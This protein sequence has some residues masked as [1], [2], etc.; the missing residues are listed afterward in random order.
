LARIALVCEPPDG[1]VAEHVMHLAR[2]LEAH[3]HT[4]LLFVAPEFKYRDV[5]ETH[6]LP[7]RRDY[8]HPREDLRALT[9]LVRGVRGMDL[10][11]SHSA[12]AGVIGR[13]AARI[14]RLPSVYTPHGFPFVGEMSKARR[15]FGVGVERGLA[16][17]TDAIICV[18]AFERELALAE[19][20]RPRRLA[21]VHNGC[22]PC[23]DVPVAPEIAALEGP[24]VGAVSTLRRA[25]RIDVLL[26]AWPLVLD[27]VPDAQ[28]VIAGE[29]PEGPALHAQ[30]A[31]LRGVTFLP[32]VPPVARYLLGLDVYVLSSSWESFPIG[33]LEAQACGV[34]QVVSAVGGTAESVDSATGV[35]VPPREPGPLAS[36]IVALLRDPERRRSMSLASREW[37][38]ARFTVERMVA[39]TAAVYG[40]V[41][42]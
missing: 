22:P 34:P 13:V 35:L 24:V 9:A 40:E 11:H 31:G 33:P 32:F 16:P 20:V 7:F 3:G 23:P 19:K 27:A 18:C 21:V 1:G 8:S 17:A 37:H 26:D 6:V 12:K 38:A 39:G 4:P 41:L 5:V 15:N 42:R 25:K 2:G 10:V 36:A 28:L 30:A 14:A 29:G